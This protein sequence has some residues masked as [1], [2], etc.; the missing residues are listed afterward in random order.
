MWRCCLQAGRTAAAEA[1]TALLDRR[2]V[3]R[4]ALNRFVRGRE[5]SVAAACAGSAFAARRHRLDCRQRPGVRPR[6]FVASGPR[7]ARFAARVGSTVDGV[8]GTAAGA[9]ARP[10][11]STL[12][13]GA[14]KG[15][16][17][18]AARPYQGELSFNR[19]LRTAQD[20]RVRPRPARAGRR[21][22]V[23]QGHQSRAGPRR[24]PVVRHRRGRISS[25]ARQARRA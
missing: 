11:R 16:G 23:P 18:E 5:L 14:R 19:R 1:L 3:A 13:P 9:V 8:R 6:A 17:A 12:R 2:L 15:R 24:P 22:G 20:D 4:D 10:A 21:R 25:H 7:R